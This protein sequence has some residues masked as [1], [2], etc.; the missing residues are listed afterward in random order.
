MNVMWVNVGMHI[1]YKT[2]NVLLYQIIT[3]SKDY[4]YY[5][6]AQTI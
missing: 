6:I 4:F 2:G 1:K 3:G 5:I